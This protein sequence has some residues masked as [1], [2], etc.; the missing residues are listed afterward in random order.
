MDGHLGS[1]RSLFRLPSPNKNICANI[2]H[3]LFYVDASAMLN[4]Q[5]SFV[6]LFVP[7]FH[8]LSH[9]SSLHPTDQLIRSAK[10]MKKVTFIPPACLLAPG[11]LGRLRFFRGLPPAASRTSLYSPFSSLFPP[12]C[13]SIVPRFNSAISNQKSKIKNLPICSSICFQIS[14]PPK[15]SRESTVFPHLF[16]KNNS[17]QRPLWGS[18]LFVPHSFF[19]FRYE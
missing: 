13:S 11:S 16:L 5:P 10:N 4:T 7:G 6:T 17:R 1:D 18:G 15:I 2:Q 19:F 9:R 14:I 8:F 3:R 12:K